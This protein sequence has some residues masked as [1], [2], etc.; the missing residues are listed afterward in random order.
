MP[1]EYPLELFP[2]GVGFIE[3]ALVPSHFFLSESGWEQSAFDGRS[4][5]SVVED[6]VN[7]LDMLV[8][9]CRSIVGS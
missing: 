7:V 5:T 3:E 9:D 1:R 2:G 8:L 6:G 4:E